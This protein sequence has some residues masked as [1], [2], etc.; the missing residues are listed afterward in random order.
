[1]TPVRRNVEIDVVPYHLN[2]EDVTLVDIVVPEVAVVPQDAV[3][4]KSPFPLTQMRPSRHRQRS[5]SVEYGG[6]IP[7]KRHD[8]ASQ[9]DS[10]RVSGFSLQGQ[11]I[12]NVTRL[13][14][15]YVG[16]L[17]PGLV[18]DVALKTLFNSALSAAFPD[19][20]KPGTEPVVSVSMHAD[21]RYAFVELRSPEMATTALQLSGQVQLFGQTISVGRP[22]GYVD[23]SKAAAA[24]QAA[25]AALAAFNSGQVSAEQTFGGSNIPPSART[26]GQV[27][28]STMATP[29]PVSAFISIEGLIEL[30]MLRSNEAYQ[31]IVKTLRNE[32]VKYGPVVQMKIPR[33]ADPEMARLLFNTG[34][35]GKAF[36]QFNDV[37]TGMRAKEG[38]VNLAKGDKKLTINF[39]SQEVFIAII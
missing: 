14:Q 34:F 19:C 6:Y 1:M 37:T 16:N 18:S 39:V 9:K 11:S 4:S 28:A 5:T 31:G 33:P 21:G 20:R 25:A 10:V 27:L 38:L 3:V 13:Q 8:N 23:P 17:V 24:A 30:E 32:C 12:Q 22:S 36:V 35:Y 26:L 7:R 29:S 2:I 15:V